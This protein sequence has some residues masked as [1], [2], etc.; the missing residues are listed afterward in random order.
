[1]GG[2]AAVGAGPAEA[3]TVRFDFQFPQCRLQQG[4][5][6]QFRFQAVAAIAVI[7]ASLG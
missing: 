5:D 2:R 1:M 4:P 3:G 7:N 6:S